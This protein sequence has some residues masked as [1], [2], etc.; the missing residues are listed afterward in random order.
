MDAPAPQDSVYY[1]HAGSLPLVSRVSRLARRRLFRLFMDEMTPAPATTILDVGVSTDVSSMEAN[2]LE[3]LYPHRDK[4]TCAGL[5]DG[6]ALR[7]TSP[8]V[9]FA[10]LTPHHPLP[11]ADKS[12]DVVYSNAVV[13]H[14]GS[15]A[16]QRDFVGE[17]ER[18]G[19]RV[20]LA[21]PNRWFPL[22]QHTALP[23]LHYLPAPL[24]RALL[25]RTPLRHWS[26]EENLN[27]LSLAE[28]RGLFRDPA[29]VGTA[30]TGIGLGPASSN[31][32]AWT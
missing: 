29:R 21:A 7:K 6:A 24:F 22:E 32:V 9:A 5:G 19:R 25:R 26:L 17:L 14:V 12:F 20:F 23:L 28:L 2:V 18:V 8:G 4:I 3:A 16:L 15:R 31:I 1:A 30:Y 11:F 27:H 10:R 13:E